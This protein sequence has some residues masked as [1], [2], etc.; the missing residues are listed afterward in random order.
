MS[1]LNTVIDYLKT[2]KDIVSKQGK[3]L[4]IEA[5]AQNLSV[6]KSNAAVYFSKAIK[7]IDPKPFVIAPVKPVTSVREITEVDNKKIA[8]IIEKANNYVVTL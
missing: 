3:K 5:I 7:V 2:Q 4:A 8:A 1:K 6:T